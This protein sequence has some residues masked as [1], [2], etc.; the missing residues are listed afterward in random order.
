M[1]KPYLGGTHVGV[2]KA[3]IL[4][5]LHLACQQQ[6]VVGRAQWHMGIWLVP[7][8]PH[9][10]LHPGS[11][12]TWLTCIPWYTSKSLQS[13]AVYLHQISVSLLHPGSFHT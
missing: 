4:P 5:L 11:T 7:A 1:Q 10:L 9:A 3:V 8:S 6:L 2:C 13:L 12:N